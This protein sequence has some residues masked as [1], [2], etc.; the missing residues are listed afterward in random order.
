MTAQFDV[1]LSNAKYIFGIGPDKDGAFGELCM[2]KLLDT[3]KNIDFFYGNELTE[4][5]QT[6]LLSL[7]NLVICF[8]DW[9]NDP[10]CFSQYSTALKH[11][12]D[13]YE[14]TNNPPEGWYLKKL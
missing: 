1:I 9:K 5:H 14:M 3:K 6:H 8:G 13:C 4:E 12:V 11:D 10:I 2:E 7:S